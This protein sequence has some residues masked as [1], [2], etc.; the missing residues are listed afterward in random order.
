MNYIFSAAAYLPVVL[1]VVALSC[2]IIFLR[3]LK[4]KTVKNKAF[5]FVGCT[6][7]GLELL[8]FCSFYV[9]SFMGFGPISI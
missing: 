1:G 7:L 6:T 8:S 3:Q 5:F 2:L 9:A 4:T